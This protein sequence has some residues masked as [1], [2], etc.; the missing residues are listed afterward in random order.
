MSQSYRLT[1]CVAWNE[2]LKISP[3]S[4]ALLSFMRS[5]VWTWSKGCSLDS[6]V[7]ARPE[8]ILQTYLHPKR[9]MT[10][11]TEAAAVPLKSLSFREQH[12]NR[13]IR[14]VVAENQ[15]KIGVIVCIYLFLS[16]HVDLETHHR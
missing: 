3:T 6:S 2:P 15:Q 7:V 5:C 16:F 11:I 12:A 14:K 13:L 8:S 4:S 9:Q 10:A 1:L